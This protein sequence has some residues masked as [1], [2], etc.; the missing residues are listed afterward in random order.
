MLNSV[1]H[2]LQKN[3]WPISSAVTIKVLSGEIPIADIPAECT[4]SIC[5]SLQSADV[6]TF[7]SPE[8]SPTTIS[9]PSGLRLRQGTL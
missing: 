6:K 1:N 7:N 8:L 4:V 9:S 5:T 2:N 3:M